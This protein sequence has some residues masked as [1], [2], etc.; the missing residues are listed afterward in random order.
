M[1][2][3]ISRNYGTNS[4]AIYNKKKK[5][6]LY[7]NTETKIKHRLENEDEE[8]LLEKNKNK[9]MGKKSTYGCT[10]CIQLFI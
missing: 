7:A 9:N 1:H 5:K 4:E 8:K 2:L 10:H 6:S 3:H